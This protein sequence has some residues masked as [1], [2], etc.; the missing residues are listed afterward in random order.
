M[1]SL[2]P[3]EPVDYLV[4]GHITRD[5]TPQGPM[6]GGTAAYAALTAR[7]MGLRAG[8]VTACA[9][10]L[11]MPELQGVPVALLP[12]ENTT[13]FENIETSKGRIQYIDTVGPVLNLSH[14]PEVWRH[15]AIVH[16][17]PVANEVDPNLARAFPNALVGLTPQGWLRSWDARGKVSFGEWPE[18]AYVLENAAAAALSIHD[19]EES[20]QRIEEMLA[21]IRILAITEGAAGVRLYWNGDLRRFRSPQVQVVDTT[22]AGDIFAAAFFIRLH[23]THDPWEAARCAAQLAAYSVTRRGLDSVPTPAEVEQCLIQITQKA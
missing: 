23:A 17:G 14:V 11:P 15:A 21:S 7:A 1:Q 19:V 2:A 12:S 13:T 20:E 16:L 8:I 18:A 3:V 5:L 9:A 22:G 6:L 4:I 10:D